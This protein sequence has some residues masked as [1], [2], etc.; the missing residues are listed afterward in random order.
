MI[1]VIMED[2]MNPKMQYDEY[3]KNH[4]QNVQ[5]AWDSIKDK[6]DDAELRS[7]TSTL[8]S[9]HDKSKYGT[10]EYIPYM[11]YFYI[12][13]KKDEDEFNIAWN[14]HQKNN[15]HH[16]QYWIIIKDSGKEI[17]LDMP[18]EYVLEML[19][20]WHSFSYKDPESTCI[21]WYNDNK[22]K[23]KLSSNSVDKVEK[24][25]KLFGDENSD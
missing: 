2:E 23:M 4:I 11:N 16:W 20:D 5:R 21:N 12:P 24:Y 19:C 3:L 1:H 15:P 22:S 10:E 17:I 13:E 25:L 8:I 6:I 18:D 14:H 7:K 9:N